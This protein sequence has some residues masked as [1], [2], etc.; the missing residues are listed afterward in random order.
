ME[1]SG[2]KTD[3][4]KSGITL[5]EMMVTL[6]L[7]SVVMTAALSVFIIGQQIF[8]DSSLT[9]DLQFNASQAMQRISFELEDSG[10]DK[11][12]TLMVSRTANPDPLVPGTD[13]LLFSIPVCVRATSL[14]D[15]NGD[16]RF[17]GAPLTWGSNDCSVTPGSN[18][19][20]DICHLPP[21]NPANC[22]SLSIAPNGVPGHLG[23]G[24]YA[25]AC[26]AACVL[27]TT[28]YTNKKVQYKVVQDVKAN[29]QT[30]NRLYRQVFDEN[31]APV[32]QA[33]AMARMVKTF[34]VTINGTTSVSLA[35]TTAG[36]GTRKRALSVSETMNVRLRNGR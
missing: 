20:V 18:G 27:D 6:L 13:I 15:Q 7:L 4:K 2:V 21:G 3:F 19:K 23:H 31:N 16:V 11:N 14:M 10:V 9:S 28:S 1:Y 22:N 34:S 33:V 35:I 25:G 12:G 24:D 36:T 29:G 5:V 32:G 26:V 8:V 30:E 17:W